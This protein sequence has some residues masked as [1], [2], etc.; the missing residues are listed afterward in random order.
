M[1]PSPSP[2]YPLFYHCAGSL[3]HAGYMS[4]CICMYLHF[5]FQITKIFSTISPS[6][7]ITPSIHIC[8]GSVSTVRIND[9]KDLKSKF[10]S[11]DL[12]FFLCLTTAILNLTCSQAL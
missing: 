2:N 7:K 12:T 1:L 4:Y 9:F 6:K 8:L 11:L 3:V 5:T 10:L